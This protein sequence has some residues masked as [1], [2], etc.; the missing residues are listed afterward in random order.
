MNASNESLVKQSAV[1]LS[2]L[3]ADALDPLVPAPPPS[4]SPLSNSPWWSY[5][6]LLFTWGNRFIAANEDFG[7]ADLH[8]LP[9]SFT[10]D[11]LLARFDAAWAAEVAH[12]SVLARAPRLWRVCLHVFAYPVAVIGAL[13]FV[14]IGVKLAEAV[15]LG[16]VVDYFQSGSTSPALGFVW[17]ALLAAVTALHA[18]LRHHFGFLATTTSLQA[19]T[20][21][22]A[23]LYRKAVVMAQPASAGLVVNL[24]SNDLA[25]IEPLCIHGHYLWIGPLETLACTVLLYRAL[26]WPSLFGVLVIFAMIYQQAWFGSLFGQF[27]HATVRWRD[28]RIRLMTDLLQGVAVVKYNAWQAPYAREVERLRSHEMHALRRSG[29]MDAAIEG[30]F[31]AFPLLISLATYGVDYLAGI[32]VSPSQLYVSTALYS[33]LRL[34]L[35]TFMP[36]GIKAASEFWVS[37]KRIAAFLAEPELPVGD[38]VSEKEAGVGPTIT[39]RDARFAWPSTNFELRV[40]DHTF[41]AGSLTCVIGPVGAGKSALFN[42]LLGTMPSPSPATAAPLAG[43]RVGYAPQSAWLLD[44]TVA[45]NIT[46]GSPLDAAWL[47]EVVDMCDLARD[48]ARWPHGLDTQ[49]GVRSL[50]LSGGQ[51]ARVALARA[52]YSRAA[53]LLLDDP[54]AAL[55]PTVGRKLFDALRTS[56]RLARTTRILATHQLQFARECES[57]L[58]VDRGEVVAAGNWAD[59][60]A[61]ATSAG[62]RAS[63]WMQYLLQYNAESTTATTAAGAA[64]GPARVAGEKQAEE[65]VVEDSE[66][67]VAAAPEPESKAEVSATGSVTLSTYVRFLI[68]PTSTPLLLLFALLMVGGQVAGVMSDWVLARWVRGSPTA[69]SADTAAMS[70]FLGLILGGV[71]LGFA[72]ALLAYWMLMSSSQDVSVRMLHAVLD[73]P[74]SWFATQPVGRILNRFAKDMSQVDEQLPSLV[75]NFAQVLF[76]VVGAVV[77]IVVVLPWVALVVPFLAVLFLYLRRKFVGASRNLKRLESTTRSP[78]YAHL[79]DSLDALPVVRAMHAQPLFADKFMALLDANARAALDLYGCTRWLAVRLD[80]ILAAFIGVAGGAA[81][82]IALGGT[83][84][85]SLAGL[86]LSYALQLNRLLQW[87]VRQSVECENMFVCVERMLQYCDLPREEIISLTAS[88]KEVVVVPN[89]W[90]RSSALEVRDMSLRYAADAPVVLDRWNLTFMPGERIGIVGRT[91]SGKSSFIQSLFAMYPVEGDFLLDGIPTSALGIPALRRRLAIIP[92]DSTLFSGTVRL[93]LSPFGE[94]DDAA[95]WRALDR[96][97]LRDTVAAMP[98]G[99]DTRVDDA[100]SA[101]ERQLLCLARALL[102]IAGGNGGAKVL[103]LDEMTAQVDQRSDELIQRAL[104]EEEGLRDVLVLIIAHR[105]ATVIDVDLTMVMVAAIVT[106]DK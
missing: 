54:L 65:F 20:A 47:A 80:L 7:E 104:A 64:T 82:L 10:A 16:L 103:C 3:G 18:F 32:P 53:T 73:A 98:G 75:F 101:G 9:S 46:F 49:V 89:G 13:G 106:L 60:M 94:H 17:V 35:T 14:E 23:M 79:S 39:L 102:R 93:N 77:V 100:F 31:F 45:E 41:P 56:P 83:L 6:R 90:P 4:T 22:S 87:M 43:R 34:S 99:L 105:I 26:G 55:D 42:A 15:F 58:V 2:T 33:I 50:K 66:P 30:S 27:R 51:K 78:V 28:A 95:L 57:I 88:E 74:M 21:L 11:P 8:P 44:G 92:Q 12:A 97:H 37:S 29:F 81:V 52:V 84:S 71:T 76:L 24:V 19:R 85:P 48:I 5:S 1:P 38:D 62:E 59:L 61:A 68:T 36:K 69:Q 25:P 70:W 86:A 91:G 72:R 96:A 63:P 67:A 40:A